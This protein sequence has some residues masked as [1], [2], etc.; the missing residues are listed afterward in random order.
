MWLLGAELGSTARA[1][2]TLNCCIISPALLEF[3]IQSDLT[4][5]LAITTSIMA[6]RKNWQGSG[7]PGAVMHH[8]W[9]MKETTGKSFVASKKIKHALVTILAIVHCVCPRSGKILRQM[10][11]A[12]LF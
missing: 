10:F 2:N 3:L 11:I 4:V 6:K 5:K 9:K 7:D 12:A 8:G 1:L